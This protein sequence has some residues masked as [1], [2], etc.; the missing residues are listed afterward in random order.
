[1]HCE[2]EL[3]YPTCWAVHLN[4]IVFTHKFKIKLHTFLRYVD[5][6][7]TCCWREGVPCPTPCPCHTAHHRTS[8]LSKRPDTLDLRCPSASR[9][10]GLPTRRPCGMPGHTFLQRRRHPKRKPPSSPSRVG[11]PFDRAPY[12]PSLPDAAFPPRAC[13][14][15]PPRPSSPGQPGLRVCGERLK[16]LRQRR[17]VTFLVHIVLLTFSAATRSSMMRLS[18][19]T[20]LCLAL[21]N[22]PFSASVSARSSSFL[23]AAS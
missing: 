20:F 22:F 8:L 16:V 5:P 9:R 18:S 12:A 19:S 13:A 7:S 10:S 23:H 11:P 14:G 21:A 17:A 4:R 15:A 1:M 3:Q 6:S 2:P